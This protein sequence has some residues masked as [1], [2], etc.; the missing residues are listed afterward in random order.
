MRLHRVVVNTW[1]SHTRMR[2][3]VECWLPNGA[4]SVAQSMA[5][6]V[7]FTH[8]RLRDGGSYIFLG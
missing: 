1:I 8:R 5:G 6:G 4:P 2:G 7:K 3:Y